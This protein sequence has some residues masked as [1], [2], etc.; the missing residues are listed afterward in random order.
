MGVRG[1]SPDT[2]RGLGELL[3]YEGPGDVE[4]VFGLN[5]EAAYDC[6]GT[7]RSQAPPP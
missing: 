5:F 7:S 2:A 1:V 3:H 6:F 4:E